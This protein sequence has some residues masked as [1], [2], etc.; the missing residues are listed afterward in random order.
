MEKSKFGI[1]AK[2]L[3]GIFSAA[4]I[5]VLPL[6]VYQYLYIIE[7]GTGFYE[8]TNFSIPLMYALLLFFSGVIFLTAWMKRKATFYKN[9]AR[10]KPV[11]AITSFIVAITMIVDAAIESGRYSALY[12]GVQ[13]NSGYDI[14]M[15]GTA[16]G[17][18]KSGVLPLLFEVIFAIL[19]SL[20][21]T[22]M[23]LNYLTAKS[24]GSHYK[25]L[26]IT[27]LA[28]CICRILHRFMRTISFIKVSDLFYELFMLVFLML[29]FMA[30]AQLISRVNHTG[31]DWKLFA[32]GLPA[33]LLCLLC[34]VP[35]IAMLMMG[36]GE[37][38]A[39]LSPPEY[40][41]FAIALF[42]VA[43]LISKVH[44]SK[45]KEQV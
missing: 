21:F 26:A 37:I 42:I 24:D 27:P 2:F 33:A 29:F 40:C 28:W 41:D 45:K 12:N 1:N 9:T 43:F 23:G 8:K 34:F 36:R 22:I 5:L 25:L 11:L 39:D 14:A 13:Q 32:F 6:R 19:A 16:G 30:F 15:T 31:T 20:F 3:L 35:R 4:I 18:M 10:K 17:L 7:P 44:I 38:L